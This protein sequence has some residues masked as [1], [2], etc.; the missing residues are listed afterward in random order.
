MVKMDIYA[1]FLNLL[2]LGWFI[3]AALE[4]LP[5]IMGAGVAASVIFMNL[6]KGLKEQGYVFFKR[7]GKE[8][9]DEEVSK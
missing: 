4:W 6:A 2:S 8:N 5:V 9:G 3:G 1:L 7:K